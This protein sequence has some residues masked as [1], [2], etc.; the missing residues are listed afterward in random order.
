M[1]NAMLFYL[2]G[3][4]FVLIGVL[5]DKKEIGQHCIGVG[6]LAILVSALLHFNI[7]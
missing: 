1:S 4:V 2:G 6:F 7:H 3:L 5:F